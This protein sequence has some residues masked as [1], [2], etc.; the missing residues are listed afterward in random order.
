[1]SPQ[2]TQKQAK[3]LEEA[4]RIIRETGDPNKLKKRTEGG[5]TVVGQPTACPWEKRQP[6]IRLTCS[7]DL[8]PAIEIFLAYPSPY[9]CL[10]Q[11]TY[12]NDKDSHILI[13]A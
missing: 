8:V 7:K 1:M 12:D 3:L 13:P 10:W 11:G 2:L 6:A 5:L 9:C 4:V